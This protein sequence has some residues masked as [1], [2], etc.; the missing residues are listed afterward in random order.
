MIQQ[1]HFLIYNG[2]NLKQGL[3]EISTPMFIAALFTTAMRGKQPKCSWKGK[4]INKMSIPKYK[5]NGTLFSLQKEK[6]L[7]Q[8]G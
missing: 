6:I 2:K 7:P 5:Y 3:K 4:W 8:H 1:S